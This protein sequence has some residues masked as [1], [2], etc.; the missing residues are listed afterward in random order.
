MRTIGIAVWGLGSHAI[1]RILPALDSMKQISLVGIC[2][3]N[4]H[5]IDEQSFAWDCIGWTDPLEMLKN[6][7]V[8]VVYIASPIGIHASQALQALNS[9]KHVWCEK[10]LSCK[11]Q[12]TKSLVHIAKNKGLMLAESF[13]YMH[14][15]QYKTAQDFISKGENG[16]LKTL[17]CR[18]GIPTLKNP[19]FRDNVSLGGGAF[20]DLASYPISAALDLLPNQNAKIIF[21]EL[22]YEGEDSNLDTKGHALLKFSG[23]ATAYLEWSTG[24][25][26][27]NELDLWFEKA[28]F[29]SDKIF[30]KPDNYQ[31]IYR[32]RDNNGTEELVYGEK[33]NQ[34]IKM[35]DYFSCS[36]GSTQIYNQMYDEILKRSELMD[37]IKNYSKF[38]N[39]PNNL[40]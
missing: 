32:I 39:K 37:G 11:H 28:S 25:A 12:D 38:K 16:L 10:P 3:R 6:N 8:D 34:F 14:H 29:F 7:H 13:M 19:G 23:G 24:I 22:I 31:P 2:S 1:K 9:G 5:N 36:I 26:Y 15:S 35:F 4:Q 30:S 40:D 27:K 33:L 20:W 17:I 18:F 21:A